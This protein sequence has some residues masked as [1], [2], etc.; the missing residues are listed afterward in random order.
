VERVGEQQAE[1]GA[2]LRDSPGV[3]AASDGVAPVAAPRER[4]DLVDPVGHRQQRRD[5]RAR[6]HREVRGG[7]P[8][9]H[10]GQRR[11]RHHDVAEPVRGHY[12]YPVHRWL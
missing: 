3:V 11:Q 1:A 12:Q 8:A 10:R 2:G 9:A 7:E 4:D 5:P 6:R